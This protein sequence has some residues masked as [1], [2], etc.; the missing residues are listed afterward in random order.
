MQAREMLLQLVLL[1]EGDWDNV[2]RELVNKDYPDTKIEYKGDYI[3]IMDEDYPETL[4]QSYKP[5][6]V[7]FYEGN[8][9]L[10]KDKNPK[11]AIGTSKYNQTEQKQLVEQILVG[12]NY[13][14]ILGGRSQIDECIAS[15]TDNSLIVVAGTPISMVDSKFKNE[16]TLI[17]SEYPEKTQ[18]TNFTRRN[19]IIIAL[20]DKTLIL[21]CERTSGTNTLVMFSLQNSKAVMVV[22]VSAF[23]KEEVVNNELIYEGATPVWTK[24]NLCE[25]MN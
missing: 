24:H 2:Y 19:Q 25:I 1:Y 11:L 22:P 16:K 4:K 3:T 5:P 8:I 14:L 18:I 21:H 15:Q 20:C 9:N 6:F 10:L 12:T 23:A 7:L 13:T 17:V